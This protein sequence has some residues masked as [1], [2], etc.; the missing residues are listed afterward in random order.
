MKVIILPPF[1]PILVESTRSIG[2]TFE[3]ALA[4]IIDNSISKDAKNIYINFRSK[5]NPYVAII[6]DG[7]GMDEKELQMAMRYGSQSSLD[8]RDKNDLG[9]FGLGLKVASMSQCRKLTVI[10]KKNNVITSAKWDLDYV[11]EKKDWAL[12]KLDL[13]ELEDFTYISKL[14]DQKS[15]TIVIWENFDRLFNGSSN[16]Q[17]L[18]DEKIEISRSHVALV[19]HRF[20]S[21]ISPLKIFFNEDK[22]EP[23]DP[24]LE[25]NPATQPLPEQD[26]II[27]G[28]VIKVK[29][30]VL[31]Y[32]SKL[33][34]KDKNMI[35]DMTLRNS[36]GFYVYRNKRLI[37]WGTWFKLINQFELNKLARVKVDI[38][39]TLDF[40]WEI[41]VKKST[42]TL[43]DIVKQ[44]LKAIVE[45]TVGVSEKVYKYRG[46]NINNDDLIHAWNHIDD[47][48]S[49][50]YSINKELPLYKALQNSL[51]EKELNYLDSLIKTIEYSFPY[52]D[53][54]YR[55]AKNEFNGRSNEL[56][57]EEVYKIALSMIDYLKENDGD[58]KSF[59]NDL[60]KYDFFIKYP[61]VIK[62][63]REEFGNE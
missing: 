29:P 9:R 19:F 57:F 62:H 58:I 7:C 18:F 12:I 43:P 30:Y 46:R 1:A 35:G 50:Q 53:L 34:S 25:N 5:D 60:D 16:P 55:V 37:I 3:T 36:Q 4:D 42:A 20:L 31:P 44:N 39:N 11:I 38:P 6:D 32:A 56:S 24:F 28:S 8:T 61:D 27:D 41:D 15:G 21:G 2:H 17:K 54:Y 63:V 59:I 48:G 49:I 52:S 51:D 40:I 33:S 45:N 10:T 23:I 22:I 47:R 14:K 13:N 26:L